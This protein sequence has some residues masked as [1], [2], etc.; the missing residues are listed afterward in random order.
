M[1]S[2]NLINHSPANCEKKM[3]IQRSAKHRIIDFNYEIREKITD[4]EFAV[5][6]AVARPGR[7]EVDRFV[8]LCLAVNI[9]MRKSK[10]P[11]CERRISF[12]RSAIF[13]VSG[14]RVVAGTLLRFLEKKRENEAK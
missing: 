8:F 1:T 10:N 2:G 14:F 5:S 11:C 9:R 6:M 3:R 4:S 12:Q 13:C 7:E